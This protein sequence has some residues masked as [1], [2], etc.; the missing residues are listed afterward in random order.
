MLIAS[1]TTIGLLFFT[2]IF[3]GAVDAIVGGG[4]LISLP[5]LFSIGLPPHLA[6]G[7]NKFQGTLGTFVATRRYYLAGL[8]DLRLLFRGLLFGLL[9]AIGG[10]IMAQ[11]ISNRWL[12]QMIPLLLLVVFIIVLCCPKLGLE[13]RPSRLS[14]TYFYPLF[15]LILGV[16]DGFLGPGTGTFWVFCIAYF[17]GQNLKNATAQ[18]KVFNLKSNIIATICFIFGRNIDY[19]IAL[20]M[21]FGQI[22]GAYLG[23]HLAIQQG[24]RFIRPV[25]ITVVALTILSLVVRHP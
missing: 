9:G 16:Y 12:E 15:G 24:A 6:L 3:A 14:V 21:V 11:W 5:V 20:C 2:G 7:T 25:F 1:Y 22:I 18:A 17:L 4:G 10:A 23:T 8:L 19:S 13:D